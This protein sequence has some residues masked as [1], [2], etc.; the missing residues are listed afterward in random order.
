MQRSL[1]AL[2]AARHPR[3]LINCHG[4]V[5]VLSARGGRLASRGAF[6]PTALAH[7]MFNAT[8]NGYDLP[9]STVWVLL[10]YLKYD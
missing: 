10:L 7:G 4:G 3:K 6:S 5:N 1:N 9:A 8:P 2:D